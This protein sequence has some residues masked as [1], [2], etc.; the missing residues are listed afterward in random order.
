M[1]EKEKV[2]ICGDVKILASKRNALVL[3]HTTY[4]RSWNHEMD[5]GEAEG[6]KELEVIS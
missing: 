5:R 6:L 3:R 2:R 4:L 1:K